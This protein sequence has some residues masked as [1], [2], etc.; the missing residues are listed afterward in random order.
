MSAFP[1]SSSLFPRL[2]HLFSETPEKCG[3]VD[4]VS[5]SRDERAADGLAYS[6]MFAASQAAA[7]GGEECLELGA[8]EG[9]LEVQAL[10]RIR[11]MRARRDIRQGEVVLMEEVLTASLSL[12]HCVVCLSSLAAVRCEA[13]QLCVACSQVLVELVFVS[14]SF[15]KNYVSYMLCFQ[16][17]VPFATVLPG[18]C[19]AA[20]PWLPMQVQPR[21]F[22]LA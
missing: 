14:C 3:G 7:G 4:R 1:P 11:G 20:V 17:C 8:P 13:C 6:N 15:A 19:H 22:P 12:R 21:P 9:S 5:W 2:F 18:H 16:Q 10:Q